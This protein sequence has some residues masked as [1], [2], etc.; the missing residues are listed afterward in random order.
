MDRQSIEFGVVDVG[1]QSVQSLT[2]T[3]IGNV[4]ATS[5]VA[6]FFGGD[7]S[8]FRVA[9][10]GCQSAPFS[11]RAGA[12]HSRIRAHQRGNLSSTLVIANANLKAPATVSV[13]VNG[14]G[15]G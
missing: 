4:E 5:I 13:S 14:R 7:A 11:H 2:L 9:E 6:G 3:N 1:A 8:S 12:D 10:N 15:G